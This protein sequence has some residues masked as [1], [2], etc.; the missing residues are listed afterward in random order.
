MKPQLDSMT[1]VTFMTDGIFMTQKKKLLTDS[2]LNIK[3]TYQECS[4][5]DKTID[6]IKVIGETRTIY[7]YILKAFTK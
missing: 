4:N 6:T 5:K 2:A 1:Q 7:T 3:K